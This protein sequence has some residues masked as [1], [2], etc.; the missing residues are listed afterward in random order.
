M[1]VVWE[2]WASAWSKRVEGE[3]SL[4]LGGEVERG[5]WREEEDCG[6]GG[7]AGREV[8]RVS[9]GW[10]DGAEDILVSVC[11]LVGCAERLSVVWARWIWCVALQ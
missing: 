1:S 11:S 3:R 8:E 6:G 9:V 5:G 7:G 10:E 4:E 2:R